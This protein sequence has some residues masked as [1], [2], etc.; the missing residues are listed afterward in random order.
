[1][2]Y[3]TAIVGATAAAAVAAGLPHAAADTQFPVN[4]GGIVTASYADSYDQFCVTTHNGATATVHLAPAGGSAGPIEHF[5]VEPFSTSCVRL[6]R[7]AE[8][9]PYTWH[10]DGYYWADG[11]G[12]FLT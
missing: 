7:A 10:V 11:R 5:T 1:M 6:S 4:I 2:L 9:T 8:N 12:T 3:K